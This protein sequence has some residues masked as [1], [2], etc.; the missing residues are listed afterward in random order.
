MSL[1]TRIKYIRGKLS[2]SEFALALGVSQRTIG[3]YEKDERDPTASFVKSICAKYAISSEWLLAGEGNMSKTADV[4][5]VKKDTELHK[6][7]N[8][9]KTEKNKIAD[10]GLFDELKELQMELQNIQKE[11]L[12]LNKEL[13][14]LYRN[15]IDAQEE[16]AN[17]RVDVERLKRLIATDGVG[18]VREDT[19]EEEANEANTA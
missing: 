5:A 6:S 1:G 10:V 8:L 16:I 15:F 3:H 12:E 14:A 13:R 19:E 2:Q 4:S 17:L 11:N 7:L 9:L 18:I